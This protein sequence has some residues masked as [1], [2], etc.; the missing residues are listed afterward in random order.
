MCCVT[1]HRPIKS[2]N[3]GRLTVHAPG[4]EVDKRYAEMEEQQ[5][6]NRFGICFLIATNAGRPAN[7]RTVS[8]RTTTWHQR[9]CRGCTFLTFVKFTVCTKPSLKASL[10]PPNYIF[11]N[12][13]TDKKQLPFWVMWALTQF[14][15][16]FIEVFAFVQFVFL[17]FP[18]GHF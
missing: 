2:I 16:V 13:V 14:L 1:Q 9:P 4:R 15:H 5:N 7:R 18:A 12:A 17:S 6:R 10:S 11:R 3:N 8:A